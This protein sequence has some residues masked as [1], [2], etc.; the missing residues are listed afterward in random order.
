MF[1][2]ANPQINRD[3]MLCKKYLNTLLELCYINVCQVSTD[4]PTQDSGGILLLCDRSHLA[5]RQGSFEKSNL[6]KR[7]MRGVSRP[8]P[9]KS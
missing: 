2:R 7:T 1:L 5:F 6:N 9:P 8:L 3:N 4:F